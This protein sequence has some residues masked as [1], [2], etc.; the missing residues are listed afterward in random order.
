MRIIFS[1]FLFLH[2]IAHLVGFL[3]PWQIVKMDDMP[4]KTTLFL[5]K[6]N[7]GDI[8]IRIIGIIWLLIALAHLFFVSW[9][10]RILILEYTL[11]LY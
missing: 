5:D 8:S 1:I 2:G 10:Y 7:I 6:I 3:V 4:Y 11:T 9:L